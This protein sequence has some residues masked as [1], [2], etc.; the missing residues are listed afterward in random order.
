MISSKKL[1]VFSKPKC[2]KHKSD[3]FSSSNLNITKLREYHFGWGLGGAKLET[4]SPKNKKLPK[5]ETHSQKTRNY[6][7]K[8]NKKHRSIYSYNIQIYASSQSRLT[9]ALYQTRYEQY[10]E[11]LKFKKNK[12]SDPKSTHK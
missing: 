5:L 11:T 1:T 12:Q 4:H 2:Q 8:I 7:I 9:Q 10:F 3:P 6:P